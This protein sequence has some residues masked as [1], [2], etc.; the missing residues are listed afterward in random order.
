[1]ENGL[2]PT[3]KEIMKRADGGE[4]LGRKTIP[5]HWNG[6]GGAYIFHFMRLGLF[7][8]VAMETKNFCN[9]RSSVKNIKIR[10]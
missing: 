7:E 9:F 2:Q 6:R 10:E 8:F 4:I 1:V 5:G 3:A